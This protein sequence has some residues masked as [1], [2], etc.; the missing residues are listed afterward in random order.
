[1]MPEHLHPKTYWEKRCAL[2][3]EA[4]QQLARLLA[5]YVLPP[6]AQEDL[7]RWASDWNRLA[8]ELN[9]EHPPEP[10]A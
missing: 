9:A 6:A 3:E 1:M 2:A 8:G 4:V 5:A 7:A 10:N